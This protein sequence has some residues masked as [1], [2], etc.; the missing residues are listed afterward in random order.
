[1][2]LSN[3]SFDMLYFYL[4]VLASGL[5]MPKGVVYLIFLL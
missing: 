5:I 2:D 4:F 3:L 1:L